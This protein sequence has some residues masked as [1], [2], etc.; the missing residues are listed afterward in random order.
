MDVPGKKKS[1]RDDRKKLLCSELATAIRKV[2]ISRK[3]HNY[4][5]E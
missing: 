4:F 5:I 3:A 1:S 2:F